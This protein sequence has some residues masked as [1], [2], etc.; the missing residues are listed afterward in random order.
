[1]PEGSQASDAYCRILVSLMA[2]RA[3]L[4]ARLGVPEVAHGQGSRE[5]APRE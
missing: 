3:A 2:L 5:S 4:A 1:M